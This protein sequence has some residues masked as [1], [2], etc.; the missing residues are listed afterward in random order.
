MANR[1]LGHQHVAP[2]H[3]ELFLLRRIEGG[4][5]RLGCVGYLLDVGR[6]LRETVGDRLKM[7]EAANAMI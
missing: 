2:Q 6:A 3:A 5:Q 1:A 7:V 4:A